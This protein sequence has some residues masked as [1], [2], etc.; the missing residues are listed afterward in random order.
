MFHGLFANLFG[1]VKTK[2][3]KKRFYCRIWLYKKIKPENFRVLKQ[4][5]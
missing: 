4:K 5:K 1:A 3:C 2:I